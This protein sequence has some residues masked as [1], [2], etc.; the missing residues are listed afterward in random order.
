MLWPEVIEPKDVIQE[1]LA[2]ALFDQLCVN[3]VACCCVHSLHI[4]SAKQPQVYSEVFFRIYY[5]NMSV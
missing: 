2:H 3:L 1:L 4:F 5:L